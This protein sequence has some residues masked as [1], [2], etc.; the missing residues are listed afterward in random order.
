MSATTLILGIG[1]TLFRDEGVGVE[2]IRRLELAD[3]LA[4]V[5]LIDGGTL[6]FTLAPAIADSPRLIVV[7]A[8]I[9]NAPPG[10]V[11]VFEGEAMDQQLSGKGKS[12]HEV[13]LMDLMDMARL[14]GTLP[15]RRALVG[16]EPDEVDWGD[17]LS[18]AV[19]AAVPLAL[20]EI[21]RLL[22]RWDEEG[23][24]QTGS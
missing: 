12:V 8:A 20:A 6:S 1:N 18:P 11:R 2:V 7:D 4:D 9:L 15:Q 5:V 24:T 14:S 10:S 22:T 19:D 17:T 23:E 3:D 16:I 21:R 13:S